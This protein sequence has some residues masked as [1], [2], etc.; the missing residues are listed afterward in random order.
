MSNKSKD[1]KQLLKKANKGK[2]EWRDN[3]EKE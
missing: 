3:H 2:G 1:A